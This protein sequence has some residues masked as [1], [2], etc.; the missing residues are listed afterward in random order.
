VG[1]LE[2]GTRT[3]TVDWLNRIAAALGVTAA[4][5]VQLPER[6]DIPVAAVL[7]AKGAHAPTRDAS[8]SPPPPQPDLIA[9]LVDASVGEYRSGDQ[10][11]CQRLAP[12]R[13]Q[14]ALN[15]DVLVPRPAGRYLFGRLIGID[16]D[17]MQI[18]PPGAG[19]RQQLV[20]TPPWIAQVATLIRS[21]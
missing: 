8:I 10:I 17:K 7:G 9:V 4:E 15:R 20:A 18:L 3:V 11:W 12:E 5:L 2:M 21:L 6:Q 1:R 13:F 19:Q 16:A 14:Q